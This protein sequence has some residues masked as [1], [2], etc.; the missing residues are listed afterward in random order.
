MSSFTTIWQC[1]LGTGWLA[2]S[3]YFAALC[4]DMGTP[5]RLADAATADHLTGCLCAACFDN[6]IHGV[7]K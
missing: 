1:N 2:C 3:V 5:L 6:T 7:T 4:S